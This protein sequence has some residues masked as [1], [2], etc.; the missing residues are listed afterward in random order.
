MDNRTNLDDYLAGLGISDADESELPPPAPDAAPSAPTLEAAP[1][2][3]RAAL[4]RFLQGLVTR[5]DPDLSVTVR[6]AEDALEAEITGEHA[7]RLAGRDGR[8]LGAIEVLA[9]T[10][11]AKQEGRGHLRVRVDVGG[12]R[13]RQA[14]T[15]TKLAERLAVQVA[16]SG[17]P[18]ELQP[19]PPA[20]R[21]V[22]H[23]A[24]KE[25]PDVMSESVGEGAA[26]RLII[27]PRHG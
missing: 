24:L 17:E 23:I 3:P 12:F 7:A 25:H 27:R 1:E 8:T 6:E 14:D 2:D 4:E 9:Y 10:V 11:L 18:H 15:L 20:E 16:K 21:R 13:K 22:I 26:R 5:I 19:M